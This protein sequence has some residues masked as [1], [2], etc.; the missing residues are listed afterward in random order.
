MLEIL[1]TVLC[2]R[3]ECRENLLPKAAKG[4]R[5]KGHCWAQTCCPHLPVPPVRAGASRRPGGAPGPLPERRGCWKAIDSFWQRQRGKYFDHVTP[6]KWTRF[7]SCVQLAQ[8]L[9]PA[10]TP[11]AA[12]PPCPPFPSPCPA[13][14][15][16]PSGTASAKQHL[17]IPG[18]F[19]GH[20]MPGTKKA[21]ASQK[22]TYLSVGRN[23]FQM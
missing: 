23:D 16:P 8:T 11:P 12:L 18:T 7:A 19:H 2:L 17:H 21:P 1:H 9:S 14:G 10:R 3:C 4:R 20:S 5:V 15:T 13:R 22:S 6:H